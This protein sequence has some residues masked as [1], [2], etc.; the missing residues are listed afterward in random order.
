MRKKTI[1]VTGG[2]GYIGSYVN[3]MLNQVGYQTIV[4]DNLSR[5]NRHAVQNGIFIHKD[6]ADTEGLRQLFQD[7][8]IDAVMHF[9]ASTDVGESVRD[10]S[11]YY[12]NNACN[13]YNLLVAM[14]NANI[15]QFIFSSTAAI[16]GKPLNEKINEEHPCNPINPYG[17]S[18]WMVEKML[19]DFSQAYGLKYGCLRYFNAAGGDPEG[20]IKHQLPKCSNLIPLILQSLKNDHSTVTIY[21]NDYPTRDGTCI[22]DYIH[23]DDLGKAHLLLLEKLLSGAPSTS[24][25][26]GNGNGFSVREVINA[27]EKTLQKKVRVIEGPRRP[28]DPPILLAESK[29]AS[30]E[31]GWTPQYELKDMILHAWQMM[32]KDTI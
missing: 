14:K 27:V 1:L 21:G 8:P 16:F 6:L 10:P 18:K 3:K 11:K 31:L 22:R 9:A 4:L 2:A 23:I 17:E 20:K 25:N 19:R 24:Y 7:Y 29:K 32:Q 26:L 28:G 5:G 13:T 12:F 30:I 15:H